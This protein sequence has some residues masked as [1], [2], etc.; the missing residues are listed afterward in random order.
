MALFLEVLSREFCPLCPQG[1]LIEG[2]CPSIRLARDRLVPISHLVTE[3]ALNSV[4]SGA[5]RIGLQGG[6][7]EGHF[8]LK[9]DDD[10]PGLQEGFDPRSSKGLGV[11]IL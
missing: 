2:D 7:A 6:L 9:F 4:K 1:G 5:G 3:L 11:V 10:G 8:R